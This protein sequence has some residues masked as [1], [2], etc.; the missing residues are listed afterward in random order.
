VA[1]LETVL[2][3]LAKHGK[4]S[5]SMLMGGWHCSVDMHVA[6]AGANFTVRSDFGL[7]TPIIA[8]EQCAERVA[9]MLRG[10]GTGDTKAISH[11]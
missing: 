5:V 4:P 7:A 3:Q 11:G 9:T 6:A 2:A 10:F 1:D 8:A